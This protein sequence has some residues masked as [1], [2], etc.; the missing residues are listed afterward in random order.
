MI[1]HTSSWTSKVGQAS[2]GSEPRHWTADHPRVKIVGLFLENVCVCAKQHSPWY[3]LGM[4]LGKDDQV[5]SQV[6]ILA[7]GCTSDGSPL[8]NSL[9]LPSRAPTTSISCHENISL[10]GCST[11]LAWFQTLATEKH[12]VHGHRGSKQNPKET[13]SKS[14]GWRWPCCLPSGSIC[15]LFNK[16]YP[17]LIKYYKVNQVFISV[18]KSSISLM[19]A[20]WW[21]FL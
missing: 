20:I 21:F 15:F 9:P 10:T 6:I 17:C 2:P 1:N 19:S 8:H 13:Q 11:A 7:Q 4:F 5:M 14:H 3:F 18:F 16:P 12:C